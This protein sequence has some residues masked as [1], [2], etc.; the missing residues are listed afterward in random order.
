MR[1]RTWAFAIGVALPTVLLGL[2]WWTASVR[3]RDGL[4]REQQ[5]VL[6]RT[7][8]AVRAAVDES[9]EELRSREDSRPFYLYNH[10]F[11]PPEVMAI[12]DPVAVS[13]LSHDPDDDRVVGYFQIDPDGTVRTP[14]SPEPS[15]NESGGRAG[16][17]AALVTSGPFAEVRS[18][19]VA[20]DAPSAMVPE[21]VARPMPDAGPA[22][23]VAATRPVRASPPRAGSGGGGSSGPGNVDT[24]GA[25]AQ[26]DPTGAPE[27]PLTVSLNPWGNE[28]FN[29]LA[30]AQE[31]DPEANL[32]VQQRGRQAPITRRNVVG[33]D[34]VQ[35]QQ[36]SPPQ[37]QQAS[38]PQQQASP[39]QQ[40]ASP[41]QQQTPRTVDSVP[42]PR[43][44]QPRRTVAV[45][46]PA[47]AP[48]P[49]V[50]Q[51]E[52]EVDYTPM[53]WRELGESLVLLRVVSHQGAAVVQGVVL[54]REALVTRWLPAVVERHAVAG[55]EPTIVEDGSEARC[56]LRSP[57]STILQDVS[58]CFAPAALM[59]VRTDAEGDA[60]LQLGALFGLLLI[61]AI[62]GWVIDRAA[63]RAEE[64]S[65]QKSAFVSAVSHELRTPLTTIRM[66][67]E[68][69]RDGLVSED[70]RARFHE[71]LVSES[72]RLSRLVSNVLE[73]SRI[74][75]GR[76]IFR[77]RRGDLVAQVRDI[78]EEQ[79]ATVESKGFELGGPAPESESIDTSFDWEAV[80]QIVVN[81]LDNAVKY[82]GGEEQ[83][84]QVRVE[85]EGD[86]AVITVLDRGPGIPPDEHERVFERF[87]RA[88]RADTAHTPGTGIGLALVRDLAR[89]HGGDATVRDRS[90]GGAEVRVTLASRPHPP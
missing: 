16:R 25:I 73:L 29:D 52:A 85:K 2:G 50:R 88:E 68:M 39:P 47:L 81:L 13:P 45:P 4:A 28:V 90:G 33:W 78:V 19:T 57:A 77:P 26:A 21:P 20:S 43:R 58:L 14:Y 24:P 46:A 69:L 62:A 40:Q 65:R 64:L 11:S 34:Q 6:R 79:R 55:T 8:D 54:D 53:A 17:M 12:S 27:G 3:E 83:C 41:Q 67:A 70:K 22:E 51:V 59:A 38:P 35:Q 61:V 30:L 80:D 18:L 89:A 86:Q 23:Q 5:A 44:V 49:V 32:R 60:Q 76:R 75:E 10:Y 7:A 37:Q 9:L 48:I 71:Q 82:G 15:T 36:A 1:R 74:E 87:H 84:I 42:R 66:H 56:S 63:R 31:G 72:V